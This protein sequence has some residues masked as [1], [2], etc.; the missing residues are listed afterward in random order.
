[1]LIDAVPA[2]LVVA[3]VGRRAGRDPVAARQARRLRRDCGLPPAPADR[4]AGQLVAPV[5]YQRRYC[6][7]GAGPAGLLMAR[8][9]VA[10]GVPF[11]WFERHSDVGGIWDMDSPGTPMYESAHFIS[12]KY[13]SGFF[14]YPMP[15]DYPD[16]PSWRQIRDYIKGFARQYGL[17]DLVTLS[18]AVTQRH[19]AA[20][21]P[22]G[23]NPF[24]R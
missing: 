21:R 4:L 11:D 14:G 1:M 20:R 17:D 7:V 23:G 12:S 9:L 13:T 24:H 15:A 6:L 18:V 16:Y 10:E 5:T 8:A 2:L 19:P 22:L 3:A